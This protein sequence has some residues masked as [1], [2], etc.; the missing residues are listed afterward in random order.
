MQ[1]QNSCFYNA[2]IS[3]TEAEGIGDD[4]FDASSLTFIYSFTDLLLIGDVI[5][6]NVSSNGANDGSISVTASGGVGPYSY[7]E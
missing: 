6:I 1:D 5:V 7:L 4:S 2:T 3:V